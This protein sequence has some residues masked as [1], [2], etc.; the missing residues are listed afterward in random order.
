MVLVPPTEQ[1][2][3]GNGALRFLCD[4]PEQ[5]EES[6]E[7]LGPLRDKLHEAFQE[8]IVRVHKGQRESARSVIDET[9]KDDLKGDILSK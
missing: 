7:R 5:V 6:M 4:S 1:P 2:Y 8:A 3:E 9:G